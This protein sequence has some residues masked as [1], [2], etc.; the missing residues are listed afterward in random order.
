MT[1]DAHI[2]PFKAS[3]ES[4]SFSP[5]TVEA[6]VRHAKGF[7]RF[8]ESYY[9]RIER[10][11]EVTTEIVDDYQRFI[12]ESHLSDGRPP[13]NTTVRLKLTALKKLFGFLLEQDAVLRDPTRVIIAPKEEQRLTRTLLTEDE[14]LALLARIEPRDATST[15]D[16]AILELFYACGIR[17]SELCDLKVSDVDLASQTVTVVHGKGGKSRILPIGQYASHYVGLYAEKAR[18]RLLRGRKIDPGALFLTAIGTPFSRKTINRAVMGRVNKLL[19]GEKQITCYAFRHMAATHLIANGVDIA[20]VAQLL[21]HESLETTKRY[22]RIEISD[23]KR[24]HSMYH[25]RERVRVSVVTS[26]DYSD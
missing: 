22:L 4:K 21:G 23:L 14:V 3:L 6:Y 5:R 10:V 19:G 9:P 15:R 11:N 24:M 18:H 13:S 16:R 20:Y 17:T 26:D 2:Q 8:L 7:D 25:P 12:R 1:I